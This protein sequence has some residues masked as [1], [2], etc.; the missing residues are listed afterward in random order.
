MDSD[1]IRQLENNIAS[2]LDSLR[3]LMNRVKTFRGT[4]DGILEELTRVKVRPVL[5]VSRRIMTCIERT[6]QIGYL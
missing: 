4:R 3:F 5:V 2:R 1:L 6:N